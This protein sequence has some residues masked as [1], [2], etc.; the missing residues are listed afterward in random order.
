MSRQAPALGPDRLSIPEYA[1]L[2]EAEA[3][4]S[5]L[6]RGVLVREPRPGAWHGRTQTRL[7]RRLDAFAE[8]GNL[9]TVFTDVGVAIP[10]KPGTVRGPDVAFYG[11]D[12]LPPPIPEGFLELAPDLAVEI[13]SP[14]NTVS[15]LLEKVIDYLDAG[16]RLV[17]VIDPRSRT[18]TVYRSRADI[19][20]L[21]EDEILE[22]GDVLPGF[23]VRLDEVLP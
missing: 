2:R 19:R 10:R 12:R 17:W 20:V 13:V 7:A 22:G 21:R 9:G 1:R 4:R 16:T 6:V 18:A 5:E 14:S 3:F 11:R 15:E 8:A 23:S